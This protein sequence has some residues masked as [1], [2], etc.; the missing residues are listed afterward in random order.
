VGDGGELKV[1]SGLRYWD[2]RENYDE[3]VS[4]VKMIVGG[5]PA[6]LGMRCVM[7]ILKNSNGFSG[8]LAS[9]FVWEL[10]ANGVLKRNPKDYTV[11]LPRS[12]K[13]S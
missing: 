10:C 1:S 5:S 8:E 11:T 12:P 4:L 6:P 7:D 3:Y 2:V 9:A 13:T